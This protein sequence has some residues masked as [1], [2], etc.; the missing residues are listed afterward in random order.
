VAEKQYPLATTFNFEVRL[1]ASTGYEGNETNKWIANGAFQEV[2]GLEVEMDVQEFYEGGYNFGVIQR[3]GRAKYNNIVLKRGMFITD[4]GTALTHLWDWFQNIVS[5]YPVL[6][7]DGIVEVK[8]RDHK[9][10]IASWAFQR[11][12]P[13]KVKGPELNAKSGEV[14]IEELHIAHEGLRLL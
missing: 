10:V 8:S 4:E 6:R 7:Y 12:L 13:A 11:G 3:I 2:S 14:A 9:T 1:M 5:G